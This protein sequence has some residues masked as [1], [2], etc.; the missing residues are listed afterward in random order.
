M[1]E[2]DQLEEHASPAIRGR[3]DPW[4]VR[5]VLITL[6]VS[7][8]TVLVILP[9]IN[10]FWNALSPGVASYW[11]NLVRNADTRH[12]ILL[13]LAVAPTAV[14]INLV[15]GIAAAWAISRFHFPGR[16]VLVIHR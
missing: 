9:V 16:T 4:Y 12:S 11:N 5:A 1:I 13:S 8:L 7:I 15:F 6:T 10:V 3:R 14:V 2:I